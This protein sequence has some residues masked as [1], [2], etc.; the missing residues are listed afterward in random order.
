M[1]KSSLHHC[2]TAV[3]DITR[4]ARFLDLARAL[5]LLLWTPSHSVEFFASNL[6]HNF[7]RDP[8]P[9]LKEFFP[10]E[11]IFVRVQLSD[12][13]ST[14]APGAG[15]VIVRYL[16]HLEAG[17]HHSYAFLIHSVRCSEHSEQLPGSFTHELS[18]WSGA[19]H[20]FG[21]FYFRTGCCI[22]LLALA[23]ICS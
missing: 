2:R 6:H 14:W 5:F 13:S 23:P 8:S 15:I 10:V 21:R 19:N 7:L 11:C 16:S 17:E 9:T 22:Q 1:S 12:Q 20:C 18:E 4:K 3:L